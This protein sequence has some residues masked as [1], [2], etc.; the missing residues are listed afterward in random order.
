MTDALGGFFDTMS[1]GLS[2]ASG[3]FRGGFRAAHGIN[4]R[5]NR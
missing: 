1:G 5:I 2:Y 3:R 4:G